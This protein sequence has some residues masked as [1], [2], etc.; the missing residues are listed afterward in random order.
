MP[1]FGGY[2]N[3]IQLHIDPDFDNLVGSRLIGKDVNLFKVDY[4]NYF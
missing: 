3:L 4:L 1:G 2:L